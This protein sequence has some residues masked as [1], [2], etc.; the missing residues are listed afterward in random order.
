MT[1][2]FSLLE[3]IFPGISFNIFKDFI[4]FSTIVFFFLIVYI[5]SYLQYKFN[6]FKFNKNRPGLI[7]K[8]FNDLFVKYI[9]NKIGLVKSIFLLSSLLLF[10]A[11]IL[12]PILGLES[13]FASLLAFMSSYLFSWILTEYSNNIQLTETQRNL[14]I[15]YFRNCRSVVSKIDD[16][17][18]SIDDQLDKYNDSLPKNNSCTN[19]SCLTYINEVKQH[20]E[21]FKSD[22]IQIQNNVSDV[23]CDDIANYYKLEE[24]ECEIYSLSYSQGE[25]DKGSSMTPELIHEHLSTLEKEKDRLSS[26]L[27]TRIKLLFDNEMRNAYERREKEARRI[28]NKNIESSKPKFDTTESKNSFNTDDV[29]TKNEFNLTNSQSS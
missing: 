4:I 14:S 6:I 20:L 23:I 2:L 16:R 11:T 21:S 10:L 7:S 9:Y 28:R 18:N 12:Y 27:D 17:I 1:Q 13:H 8:L 5:S 19:C 3:E 25:D 15:I 26:N 29:F 22:I 24:I